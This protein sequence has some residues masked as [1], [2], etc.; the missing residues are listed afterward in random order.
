[1]TVWLRGDHLVRR[2]GPVARRPDEPVLLIESE[3]FA[4]K[5]PY[6]PHKLILLFSAMRHFRDELRAD[7]RPVRYQQAETF[8]DGL[9]AHFEATP[10]DTLVTHRPQ[11]GAAQSRLESLVADAGGTVEFVADE[12]FLCSPSQ[13]DGWCSD[14]RYRHEDFYRFMRRETGYLMANGDPVGGEWNYDDQNRETPPD[15]WTPTAPPQFEPDD[16]TR[17]V[18][19]WVETTFEGSYDERPYGGDWADPEPFRWPVTR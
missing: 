19:E 4:R 16:V 3:A 11:T 8:E 13:F 14:G 7:G 9:A 10:D 15:E 12:R 18:V 2:S 1:M 6:H 5:L 17:D